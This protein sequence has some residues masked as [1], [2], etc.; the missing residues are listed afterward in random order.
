MQQM[1][2]QT[3]YVDGHRQHSFLNPSLG[4]PETTS[5]LRENNLCRHG[6]GMGS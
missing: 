2:F 6:A 3:A 5:D 4:S 1:I